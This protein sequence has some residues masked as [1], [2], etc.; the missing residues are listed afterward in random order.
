MTDRSF[1]LYLARHGETEYNRRRLMQGRSV[2]ASLNEAGLLQ[3]QALA[4][5]FS[6]QRVDAVYASTLE[7]SLQTAKVVAER[8]G[9]EPTILPEIGEMYW[10]ALEGQPIA[11]FKE[12]L[13]EVG[14]QWRS[15]EFDHRVGGGESIL[16]VQ[17]RAQTALGKLCEAHGN[18]ENV[19]VVTHG[20]FLRVILTVALPDSDLTHMDEFGHANTGIYLLEFD[21]AVFTLH[22]RNCTRHLPKTEEAA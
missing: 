21:G 20:R 11:E 18:G 12:Y 5:R 22:L 17:A 10:G 16:D 6:D 2:N 7:R 3:A 14:G 4:D 19:V 8:C 1:W 13:K 15:G 9:H